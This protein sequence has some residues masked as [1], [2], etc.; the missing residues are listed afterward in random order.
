MLIF[1]D[2]DFKSMNTNEF[3][4]FCKFTDSFFVLLC[5]D[6]LHR[7]P[8]SYEGIYTIKTSG[9]FHELMPV[10]SKED[11]LKFYED[12]KIL[13]EDSNFPGFLPDIVFY[14]PSLQTQMLNLF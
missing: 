9:R 10:F 3:A 1:A 14:H 2:E 11:F 7:L 5:R 13:T 8:Y 12:R 6:P 4:L